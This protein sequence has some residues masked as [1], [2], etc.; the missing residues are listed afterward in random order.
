MIRD[1]ADVFGVPD[2]VIRSNNK[3]R[4]RVDAIKGTA[5]NQY[6]VVLAEGSVAMIACRC[7]LI[8]SRRAAPS[9]HRERKIHADAGDFHARNSRSFFVEALGLSIADRRVER[10]D[11]V[12]DPG[13][14]G[15]RA[16]V[17][18]AQVALL[19]FEIRRGV[20]DFDFIANKLHRIASKGD[21]SHYFLLNVISV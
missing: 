12:K 4:S 11:A 2:L 7:D 1:L 18:L 21:I 17:I 10:G 6:A 14:G 5:F 13:L 3:D 15:R 9:L 8:H 16:Q 20:A 19:Y